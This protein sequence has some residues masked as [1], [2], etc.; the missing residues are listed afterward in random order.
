MEVNILED[1]GYENALRGMSYSFKDRAEPVEPWWEGQFEKAT[2]RAE[3]LSQMGG[4][5][6]D[7]L[8]QI[9]VWIDVEAPRFW[10]SEMDTYH[11]VWKNSE[12]TMHTLS[13]RGVTYE[14]FEYPLP[15]YALHYLNDLIDQKVP[16]YILKNTLPDGFLQR[17]MI[18]TN[19][20]AL[21]N[22][23]NQR[24]DHRLP[25]WRKFV[26]AIYSQVDHPELLPDY[27]YGD[28]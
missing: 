15:S 13:K 20:M 14:D 22:I 19:Y 27:P 2:K 1:A 8:K 10:W 18:T 9:M 5:H 12:S 23:I 25:Q 28:D 21:R 3:K 17:R 24:H 26:E 11:F 7:F 6:N 16:V 4:G